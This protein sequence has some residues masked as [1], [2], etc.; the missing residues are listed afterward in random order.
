MGSLRRFTVFAL[1]FGIC[2]AAG[3]AHGAEE[4]LD[5]KIGQMLMVGFRGTELQP[6]AFILEAIRRHHLGGVILFD[7]DVQQKRPERNITSPRQLQNLIR[8]LQQA[9]KV[10]LLI[11]VDQEGGRV[12]RL[13][14]KYG[15][16]ATPS[17]R[18]LGQRDDPARTA[19]EAGRIAATLADVGITV[20]FA[21]VV[22]LC[23]NP[24]NPVIARLGRCFSQ[25]PAKVTRH[26]LAYIRAHQQAGVA[27]VL[28][29]FPGHGSSRDD[30]H[31]G[32]TDVTATWAP[33]ELQPYADLIAADAV[34]AVMTAHVFNAG[35]DPDHPAT[36]SA[37]TITGMLREQLG[38]DG[39]VFSDDLQMAAISEHYGLEQAVRLALLA[40]VDILLFGNN[41]NYDPEI[42]PK[43]VKIIREL[44]AAEEIS[45][46]RI[47]ESCRRIKALKKGRAMP[48]DVDSDGRR[49]LPGE[50]ALCGYCEQE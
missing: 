24:D 16:P 41:L 27:T 29:H 8:T 20:N 48:S 15:F 3:L 38:F 21:P 6:D 12:A 32:F 13:K 43:V 22:D 17:H 23:S 49:G 40:G 11:A 14:E 45:K 26:A 7:Y 1:I 10:P 9:A 35:V 46:E 34:S 39:V 30:S 2:L 31:L 28:K 18:E 4:T 25:Q 36:L 47:D 44:V 5:R 42:V 19:A 33:D 37:A 50:S